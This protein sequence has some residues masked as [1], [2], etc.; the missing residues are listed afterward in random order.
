MGLRV[1]TEFGEVEALINAA[2]TNTPRR[3]L[4]VLSPGDYH[5]IMDANLNV[6]E[7]WHVDR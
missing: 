6:P 1:L 3:S 5:A 7:S 2:G 4:E